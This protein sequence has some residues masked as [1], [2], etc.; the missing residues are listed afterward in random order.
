M[1]YSRGYNPDQRHPADY[2]LC[3]IAGIRRNRPRV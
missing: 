1:G 3:Y 2:T